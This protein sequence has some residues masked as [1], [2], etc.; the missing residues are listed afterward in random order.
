MRTSARARAFATSRR[1]VNV[2][3]VSLFFCR[4]LPVLHS[5]LCLYYFI[6]FYL[7]LF[8]S[9][10]CL[11]MYFALHFSVCSPSLAHSLSH[12]PTHSLSISFSVVTY[13]ERMTQV[14][15]STFSFVL[16]VNNVVNLLINDKRSSYNELYKRIE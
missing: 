13:A 6:S 11:I 9:A 5:S 12:S 2:F 16:N 15:V 10:I 14:S 8:F 4:C 1:A 7:C 3:F